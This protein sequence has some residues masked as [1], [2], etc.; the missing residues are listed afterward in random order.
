MRVWGRARERGRKKIFFSFFCFGGGSGGGLCVGVVRSP[1]PSSNR[2]L[3]S[4]PTSEKIPYPTLVLASICGVCAL[5]EPTIPGD[6]QNPTPPPPNDTMQCVGAMP[7]FSPSKGASGVENTAL[8]LG[9]RDLCSYRADYPR[10]PPETHSTTTQR[11][12]SIR[13]SDV[14][15]FTRHR[16]L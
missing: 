2:P 12:N 11:Q 1:V 6:R 15:L 5:T 14:Y 10:R 13:W 7:Y 8:Q 16:S 4:K 3:H 9:G